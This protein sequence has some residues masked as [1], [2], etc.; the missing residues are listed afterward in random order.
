MVKNPQLG[1]GALPELPVVCPGQVPASLC[2]PST[3]HGL[4]VCKETQAAGQGKQVAQAMGNNESNKKRK[5]PM[6]KQEKASHCRPLAVATSI[7]NQAR[8]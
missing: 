1:M 8:G 5:K 3:L 4:T 6:H 7:L 2:A